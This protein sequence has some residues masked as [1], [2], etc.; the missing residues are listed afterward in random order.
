MGKAVNGLSLHGY[1]LYLVWVEMEGVTVGRGCPLRSAMEAK[2]ARDAKEAEASSASSASASRAAALR[3][4]GQQ[5]QL[6]LRQ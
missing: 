3:A 2:G 4:A 6:R 1:M 5:P